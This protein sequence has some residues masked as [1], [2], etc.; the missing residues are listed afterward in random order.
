MPDSG[1]PDDVVQVG[2]RVT[3]RLSS[4]EHVRGIE[5]KVLGRFNIQNGQTLA[6]VEWDKLGPPRRLN[7]E[8]LAKV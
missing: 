7:I 5:G 2:D 1:S 6:D 4:G 3:Y 8:H